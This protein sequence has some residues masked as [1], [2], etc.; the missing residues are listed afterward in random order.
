MYAVPLTSDSFLGCVI[1]VLFV[2]SVAWL[3]LIGCQCQCKW[4]TGKTRLRNDLGP[5]WREG[6][7]PPATG[8]RGYYHRENVDI[9]HK[10]SCTFRTYLHD[11][12]YI[13]SNGDCSKRYSQFNGIQSGKILGD[14]LAMLSPTKLL[15]DMF[16]VPLVFRLWL[17][18]C[19]QRHNISLTVAGSPMHRPVATA[20]NCGWPEMNEWSEWPIKHF[21]FY[22]YGCK[23]KGLCI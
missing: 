3:F 1:F 19:I 16:P 17:Y 2:C 21:W 6:S 11:S 22:L 8:V 23:I 15:G 4:L 13:D 7:P 14:T 20:K 12:R 5:P 18:I 10:K 9:L